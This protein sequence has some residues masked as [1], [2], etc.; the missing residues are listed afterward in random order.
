[1]DTKRY[2]VMVSDTTMIQP[3]KEGW[4]AFCVVSAV[5]QQW[6]S[7]S[8]QQLFSAGWQHLFSAGRQHLFSAGWQQLFLAVGQ[9]AKE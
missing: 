1:M 4:A 7:A 2:I 5:W 8:Q 6:F 3:E 9:Q